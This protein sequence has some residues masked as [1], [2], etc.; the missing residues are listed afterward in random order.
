MFLLQSVAVVMTLAL[1]MGQVDYSIPVNDRINEYAS[2]KVAVFNTTYYVAAAATPNIP[3][4]FISDAEALELCTPFAKAHQDYST[5]HPR[6]C[7]ARVQCLRIKHNVWEVNTLNKITA[8]ALGTAQGTFWDSEVGT[9][10]GWNTVNNCASDPCKTNTPITDGRRCF[11]YITCVRSGDVSSY[12]ERECPVGQ[13]FDVTSGTCVEDANCTR[14]IANTYTNLYCNASTPAVKIP[15]LLDEAYYNRTFRNEADGS[16][17]TVAEYCTASMVFDQS[18]PTECK[19][20]LASQAICPK[21]LVILDS[22]DS[23]NSWYRAPGQDG[24]FQIE[25]TTSQFLNWGRFDGSA[26]S[27]YVAAGLAKNELAGDWTLSFRFALSPQ[28]NSPASL[29]SNSLTSSSCGTATLRVYLN[30]QNNVVAEVTTIANEVATV[31][32]NAINP[33]TATNV[34]LSRNGGQMTLVV[35]GQSFSASQDLGMDRVKA[36]NCGLVMGKSSEMPNLNGWMDKV[37]LVSR[38]INPSK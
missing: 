16:I 23:D 32:S 15:G 17:S 13:G 22:D 19:C 9:Q 29:V 18:V 38:C 24:R 31:Q 3:Q 20:I 30:A 4:L 6:T 12:E 2:Q 36:T 5:F 37:L 35:N 28:S 26:I 1:A 25:N 34:E 21:T 11:T 14:P 8:Y 33:T 7:S 27:Y 10:R